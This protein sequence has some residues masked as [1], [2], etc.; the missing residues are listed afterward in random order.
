[1]SLVAVAVVAVL[2]VVLVV[3]RCGCGEAVAWSIDGVHGARVECAP[4]TLPEL[5][6]CLQ[7]GPDAQVSRVLVTTDVIKHLADPA[8]D[9]SSDSSR[10]GSRDNSARPCSSV[11]LHGADLGA[12]EAGLQ[13][14][15]QQ[16][17]ASRVT[18]L[19]VWKPEDVSASNLASLLLPVA[20]TLEHLTLSDL[21]LQSEPAM[22]VLFSVLDSSQHLQSLLL[23]DVQLG[24]DQIGVLFQHLP[25]TLTHLEIS[26]ES[27]KEVE[28]G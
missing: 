17:T 3:G 1:M 26:C 25:S 16:L 14:L 13:A 2:A 20:P 21:S 8:P 10:D 5:Q 12:S 24:S 9:S 19:T 6:R 22:Q 18:S 28:R 7:P 27:R 4:K 11:V 15:V 23:R